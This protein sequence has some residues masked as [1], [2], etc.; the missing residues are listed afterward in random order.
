MTPH[1][2]CIRYDSP[3]RVISRTQTSTLQHTTITAERH[4]SPWR[5]SNPQSQQ[6][7]YLVRA[8]TEIGSNSNNNNNNN[9]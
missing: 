2:Q 6:V 7:S 3:G 1:T 8:A 5:D 9:N 4:I